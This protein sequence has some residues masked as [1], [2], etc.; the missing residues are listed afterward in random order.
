[1]K[2]LS[3]KFLVIAVISMPFLM[4][5]PLFVSSSSSSGMTGGIY[6]EA[7]AVMD[8]N[9]GEILFGENINKPMYP[10]SI[11][12][13]VTAIITIETQEMDDIVTVSEKAVN[14]IGTRV[15]L[16]EGE[17]VTIQQLLHGLMVSSG[18][19]AGIALAEHI[20]GSVDNFA[21]E[22]NDFLQKRIG[23]KN[24]HFTNPHGLFD[25]NHITTAKDMA[26]ISAYAMKNE[27]FRDLVSTE[28]VEWVGEG[29]ETVLYNH[30]PLLRDQEM[31]I[32]I[33][34]GYV[35]KSG[36]TLATAAVKEDT[37]LI[38]ITLSSPSR[39]H[40]VADTL[41]LLDYA[42]ANYETQWLTFEKESPMAEFIFPVKVPVST[43][44]GEEITFTI[45]DNGLLTVRGEENR[46][47][48]FS[49]LEE[50]EPLDLPFFSYDLPENT[51]K[52]ENLSSNRVDAHNFTDWLF[53][54]GFLFLSLK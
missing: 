40:G 47:I 45:S 4:V 6:S 34:N 3:L 2:V 44:K 50:R 21:N 9:T 10:A 30:H 15:Y 27:V 28:S 24:T 8:A 36:Y 31:V 33:K 39:N 38:I 35:R 5:S 11:T 48:C 20:A 54:T 18:N 22:M 29:W 53:V 7:Y 43:K 25:K 19:D 51:K 46:L 12:K 23:V 32:G 1:M 52:E 26:E 42:F 17:E 14:A 49:T 16:L 41:K 37:E 13:M